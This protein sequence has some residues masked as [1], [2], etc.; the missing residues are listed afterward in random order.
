MN[1][2]DGPVQSGK[3]KILHAFAFLLV[4]AGA[5]VAFYKMPLSITKNFKADTPQTY[6]VTNTN[7]SGAG[8]LRTAITNANSN[9]AGDTI[10]FSVSG[11]ITLSS[12]LPNLTDAQS[13]TIDGTT[14]PDDLAGPDIKIVGSSAS[15]Y[16]V[17][18]FDTGSNNIIKGIGITGASGSTGGCLVVGG[19]TGMSVGGT[20]ARDGN[21]FDRC[22]SGVS[23]EGGS[24]ITFY[25]NT[26]GT[27][28]ANTLAGIAGSSCSNLTIGGSASGQKNLFYNNESQIRFGDCSN[29]T[30]KGNYIGLDLDGSTDR[31]G[32]GIGILSEGTNPGVTIGGTA[33]GER[34]YISGNNSDGIQLSTGTTATIQGNYIGTN[35]AGTAAVANGGNGISCSSNCTVG[36]TAAGAGNLISGNAGRGVSISG[37]TGGAVVQGNTIGLN[38]AGTAAIANAV[39]A[40]IENSINS[41]IGGT[42][43][44]ARNIISGNTSDGVL[45]QGAWG[46]TTGN[47]VRMNY[48]G[49]NAAGTAAIANGDGIQ[50]ANGASSNTIGGDGYG[51]VISGNTMW[52][53]IIQDVEFFNTSNN[54]LQGNYIGTNAAGTSAIANGFSGVYVKSNSNTIGGTTAGTRNIISGNTQNGIALDGATATGNIIEGNYIGT[55]AAGTGALANGEGIGL[56]NG[57]TANY[58]GFAGYG[59]VISGNAGNGILILG[60]TSTGNFIR[61]NI[62]GLAADG[63]SNLGNGSDGVEITNNGNFVGVANDN[64]SRNII[65]KN[66]GTGILL[67]AANNN[68]VTNNCIGTATDCVT[69]KANTDPP[70]YIANS[71]ASSNT[72]G[73]TATGA[74][75]ILAGGTY[76][77]MVENTAGNFNNIRAN[78]CLTE[79]ATT[80]NIGRAGASNENIA[81]PTVTSATATT[82]YIEGNSIANGNLDIFINGTYMASVTAD[83]SGVWSKAMS[84][85]SGAKVSVSV[86][87]ATQSTSSTS[88]PQVTVTD[89]LTPSAQPAVSSPSSG[90]SVNTQTITLIGTKEANTSIWIDGAKEV[91]NNAQTTWTVSN[92]TLTE[93]LNTFSIL[94]KDFSSNSSTTLTY[95][96]TYDQMEVSFSAATQSVAEDIGTVTITVQ[97]SSAVTADVVIPYTVSGT[98]TGS[99]T[100]YNNLADGNL[101]VATGELT[102]TKSVSVINDAVDEDSETMILTLGTPNYGAAVGTTVH[103]ITIA[104]DDT[105]GSTVSAIS[106]TLTEAGGTATFTVV[107]TSQPTASVSIPVSSSDTT[108]GTIAVSTVTFTSDNWDTAQTVTVTGVDDTADDGDVTFSI[109]TG[110]VTSSD[111][112]YD[113]L[114]VSDVTVATIDDDSAPVTNTGTTSTSGGGGG[115][116]NSNTH[117]SNTDTTN[118]ETDDSNESSEGS[119]TTGETT[120]NTSPN[121]SGGSTVETTQNTENGGSGTAGGDG[122]ETVNNQQNTT[123]TN[124]EENTTVDGGV[125]EQENA[126]TVVDEE[127]G[128]TVKEGNAPTW[129][130]E[131]YGVT[132]EEFTETTDTDGDGVNNV[133]EYNYGTNPQSTDTDNDKVTDAEE[134]GNGTDPLNVDSDGDGL[135]DYAETVNGT[136][137]HDAD[138]D[139]DGYTDGEEAGNYES[140][141]TNPLSTPYDSD[142]DGYTDRYTGAK[143]GTVD[144]DGD[145]LTDFVE[146]ETHTD[147]YSADTDGDVVSDGIE[148]LVYG[149]NPR[150]VDGVAEKKVFISNWQNGDIAADNQPFVIGVAPAGTQVELVYVQQQFS[151]VLG[152]GMSTTEGVFAIMTEQPLLD[153]AYYL[154]ARSRDADSGTIIGESYPIKITIDT[155]DAGVNA[156]KLLTLDGQVIT[157]DGMIVVTNP[158][159]LLEVESQLGIKTTVY[160]QSFLLASTLF[161]DIN[162]WQTT[163]TTDLEAG[164]HTVYVQSEDNNHIKG[165]LQK[166]E[167]A[168]TPFDLLHGSYKDQTPFFVKIFGIFGVLVVLWS[169]FR[170]K[171]CACSGAE[172]VEEKN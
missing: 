168:V 117:A 92:V 31:G 149:T 112:K 124:A 15:D 86:T 3:Y 141:P 148:V 11:T 35:A 153:G 157:D 6:T 150:V 21:T 57:A 46:A 145:G 10:E 23:V 16:G 133:D 60:A 24:N 44:A 161:A 152:T 49:I 131:T 158:R 101:T 116:G 115:S 32:I 137:A 122:N 138:S 61:A 20:G 34:N 90:S 154:F 84:I 102:V 73:G 164:L 151:A 52:G 80:F 53:V 64:T 94:A 12:T 87:N 169:E 26:F 120:Q 89:D 9:A 134:V 25:N 162:P 75:N 54:I 58:L 165:K 163:P 76:C 27:T 167:F 110:A 37:S 8:S 68:V 17:L 121:E 132:E 5:A 30:I 40:Y 95:T 96:I 106:G 66:G 88:T 171:Q 38:A 74:G 142:N 159:P 59:N 155:S 160:W 139:D 91:E 136:D 104:D 135:S 33:A 55:N 50:I 99:G 119:P 47:V 113:G 129:W 100:D 19:V 127:L 62:I 83:A 103:T 108:E 45:L 146:Y 111:G 105:A 56:S 126:R 79:N 43:S 1:T 170:K 123:T 4:M 98:A 51:N 71:S 48:I 13:V 109:V 69:S 36:G 166:I 114:S 14:A 78:N 81:T 156:V 125:D 7:D 42:T 63:T 65:S 77:V 67:S 143:G 41:T 85:T 22:R 147:P 128:I 72:I 144:S 140:D 70:V 29:V 172:S 97:L 28:T 2:E 18:I 107:L 93:G 82:S 118:T 130:L 39:G